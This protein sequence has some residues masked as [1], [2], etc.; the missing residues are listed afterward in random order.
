MIDFFLEKNDPLVMEIA[1]F[2]CPFFPEYKEKEKHFGIHITEFLPKTCAML[3]SVLKECG[4]KWLCADHITLGDFA[5]GT[6]LMKI[7]Y[8][9]RFENEH[10]IRAVI[11]K[12]PLVEKWLACFVEYTA[13]WWA[14]NNLYDW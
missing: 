7:S 5:I 1:K 2:T 10:I 4:T 6:H 3:E 12:Y 9:P 11:S 14:K 8:N 13:E